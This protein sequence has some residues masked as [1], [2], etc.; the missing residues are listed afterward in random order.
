[1]EACWSKCQNECRQALVDGIK[2]KSRSDVS[3]R[4]Y[5]TKLS[6]DAQLA[7]ANLTHLKPTARY[8]GEGLW[9]IECYPTMIVDL[10]QWSGV[11]MLF[12]VKIGRKDFRLVLQKKRAI[13][14][15]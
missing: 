14:A 15:D 8:S 3:L 9:A 5:L 2:R 12:P 1:M 10:M 11:R 4:D 6:L 13:F 7:V